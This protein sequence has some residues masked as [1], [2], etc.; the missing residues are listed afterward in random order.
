[1][2]LFTLNNRLPISLRTLRRIWPIGNVTRG[3]IPAGDLA[4]TTESG[5]VVANTSVCENLFN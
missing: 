1:M 3:N 5:M 4:Y 2:A